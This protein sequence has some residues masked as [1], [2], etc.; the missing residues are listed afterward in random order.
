MASKRLGRLRQ[1]AGEVISTKEK[2]VVTEETRELEQ[3][4]EL[5]RNGIDR[6][7]L[8]AAQY[9]HSLSKKKQSLALDD[10]DK[11][12]PRDALGIVLLTHG[13]EFGEDSAF[14]QCLITL[15]RAHCKIATLQEAFA[16]TL[17]DSFLSTLSKFEDEIKDYEV[18]RKKLETRRLNYDAALHKMDR[19][20]GSKKDKERQEAEDE[21]AKAKSHYEETAEDVRAR[22]YAIQDNEKAQLRELGHFLDIECKYAEQYLDV[23]RD[24]KDNWHE[25]TSDD[26]EVPRPV[27]PMHNFPLALELELDSNSDKGSGR[28]SVKT[29]KSISSTTSLSK[30]PPPPPRTVTPSVESD[31]LSSEEDEPSPAKAPSR[32]SSFR[33][34]SGSVSRPPSRPASRT[35]RKRSDSQTTVGS[36]VDKDKEK[37]SKGLVSGWT[38]SWRGKKGRDR[39]TFSNLKDEET[40][41]DDEDSA[42]F[43]HSRSVSSVSL[44]LSLSSNKAKPASKSKSATSSPVIPGRVP[45]WLEK[46]KK[47]LVRALYDFSGSVDELSFRTGD[48]IVVVNEVLDDWWMGE[49]GGKKGLFPTSYTEVVERSPSPSPSS[50]PTKLKPRPPPR[51]ANTSAGTVPTL[52]VSGS[53]DDGASKQTLVD[54]GS[55]KGDHPFGDDY[56]ATPTPMS[57]HFGFETDSIASAT[58]DDDEEDARLMPSRQAEE[59]AQWTVPKV[60]RERDP[61][62][63]SLPV[64]RPTEM[65][66][67]A[68]PPPPPRRATVSAPRDAAAQPA[69]GKFLVPDG[70]TGD[71]RDFKQ[72]P[73][74][75]TGMCVNCFRMHIV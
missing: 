45:K 10:P 54:E 26:R 58:E 46:D 23:L 68:P 35:S 13:E 38:N 56:A 74:K 61:V 55:G 22:I 34:R 29:H 71:C 11:F 9:H 28:N 33:S 24:V 51:R 15:G 65:A 14:G 64:R 52:S 21:L 7:Q 44:S 72:N 25:D 19:L 48:E 62:P 41:E 30:R 63:P 67:K 47:K 27:G 43:H 18:E 57:G 6:L 8:A 69:Q 5:R 17:K 20:K 42:T 36:T 50:S 1:W 3:D 37:R 31:A 2:S 40:D 73:F 70:Q 53:S 4:I 12:L 49:V 39:E 59:D 32:K 16:L 66:R 60:V 75:A